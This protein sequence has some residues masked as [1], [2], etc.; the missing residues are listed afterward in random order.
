M[1]PPTNRVP[2]PLATTSAPPQ[3]RSSPAPPDRTRCLAASTQRPLWD[4][5]PTIALSAASAIASSRRD[6]RTVTPMVLPVAR[7]YTHLHHIHMNYLCVCAACP[8]L[9]IMVAFPPDLWCKLGPR[10]SKF[11]SRIIAPIARWLMSMVRS[12]DISI[13]IMR[14]VVGTI[15]RFSIRS[16]TIQSACSVPPLTGWALWVFEVFPGC[17]IILRLHV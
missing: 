16:W 10:R 2:A 17:A 4:P 11:S 1:N 13:S 7:E 14:Q 3:H 8:V 15:R 5:G 6:R 9:T 12:K